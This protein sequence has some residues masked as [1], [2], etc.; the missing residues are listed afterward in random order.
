MWYNHNSEHLTR[1]LNW[2]KSHPPPHWLMGLMTGLLIDLTVASRN[3]SVFSTAWQL[4][5]PLKS[6]WCLLCERTLHCRHATANYYKLLVLTFSFAAVTN[7]DSCSVVL[8]PL[9]LL[10][11][12]KIWNLLHFWELLVWCNGNCVS[13]NINISLYILMKCVEITDW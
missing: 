6:V 9:M 3:F 8:D 12:R 5:G 10:I 1:W 11:L 2:F 7:T 4:T 13:N